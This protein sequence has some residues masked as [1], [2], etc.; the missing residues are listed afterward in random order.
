[1]AKKKAKQPATDDDPAMT[2][3]RAL[4]SKRQ[5]EGWTFERL[6]IAMGASP[7]SARQTVYQLLKGHDPRIGTLRRFAKAIGVSV[8]EI[9]S[10]SK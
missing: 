3:V 5:S 10:D 7:E 2:A 1:M 6:G 8:S 9:V 4:W